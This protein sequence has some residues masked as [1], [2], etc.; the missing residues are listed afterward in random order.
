D[1]YL[2]VNTPVQ[3]AL[4]GLLAHAPRFQQALLTRVKENRRR[5][6]QARP[7]DAR[8]DVLPAQGGWSTVLRIPLAPGEEATCLALLN[9]GVVVQ[10]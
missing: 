10:P 5:L 9:E 4:P 8:W 1:T 6:L 2:P 3:L 7:G